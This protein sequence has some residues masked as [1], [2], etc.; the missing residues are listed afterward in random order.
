MCVVFFFLSRP[1]PHCFNCGSEDHQMKDC[2]KVKSAS[3]FR[4]LLL[5]KECL[6]CNYTILKKKKVHWDWDAQDSLSGHLSLLMGLY[7]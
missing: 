7:Y 6:K 5:F 3:V 4:G 1:K 2:P